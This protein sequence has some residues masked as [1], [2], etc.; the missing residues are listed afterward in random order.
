MKK[1]LLVVS[2]G[3]SVPATRERT[4]TALEYALAAAFPDR[5]FYR[6]WTSGIIRKKILREEGLKIDSVGNAMERI[7]ADGVTDLL[8]QPTHLLDGEENRIMTDV[9][10]SAAGSLESVRI[11]APLLGS[12]EDID[13]LAD[14]MIREY[15]LEGDQLFA[16][17]GH[18]SGEMKTN[19]YE[20]LNEL[21]KEKGAGNMVVGT[22]E[23]DP[24]F[25]PI[26]D[27]I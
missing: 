2:F 6:A 5:T 3:T 16:W 15:P 26:Q 1:A 9:V 24:G 12:E 4:V 17:M 23:Y 14:I 7:V 19:V 21:L 13:R 11:G 8:V 10:R 25:A 27:G 18:G 22:V 20:R